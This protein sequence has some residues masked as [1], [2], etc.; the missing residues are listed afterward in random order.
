LEIVV[1]RR[2]GNSRTRKRALAEEKAAM[3]PYDCTI[4]LVSRPNYQ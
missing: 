1:V 2:V 4:G 3:T